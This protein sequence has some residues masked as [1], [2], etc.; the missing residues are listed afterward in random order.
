MLLSMGGWVL[1]SDLR[2]LSS[3]VSA[4]GAAAKLW[5]WT[6]HLDGDKAL[7]TEEGVGRGG[8]GGV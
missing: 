7:V 2:L 1:G 5:V 3:V 6:C 8:G 4:A